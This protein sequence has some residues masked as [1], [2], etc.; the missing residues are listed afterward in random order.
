[1]Q[2]LLG[3]PRQA[4]FMPFEI[5][6]LPLTAVTGFIAGVALCF[7]WVL[8]L[9]TLCNASTSSAGASLHPRKRGATC[10]S[11]E[12]APACASSSKRCAAQLCEE[13]GDPELR[14]HV[15]SLLGTGCGS[16]VFQGVR[17]AIDLTLTVP[18]KRA[19]W[20]VTTH[21]AL[22]MQL[23]K[24][25]LLESA[26]LSFAWVAWYGS[27]CAPVLFTGNS[28]YSQHIQDKL[29]AIGTAGMLATGRPCKH[30]LPYALLWCFSA[31]A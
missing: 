12:E 30:H 3:L 10:L 25:V 4:A 9:R 22:C 5:P 14:V 16:M 6:R 29:L 1:M 18:C 26:S 15:S 28:P 23:P 17:P 31:P 2:H 24:Q 8:L 19:A 21:H 20:L 11:A 13:G 27:Q 7:C